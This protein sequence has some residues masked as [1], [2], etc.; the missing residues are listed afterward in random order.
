[1]SEVTELMGFGIIIMTSFMLPFIIKALHD[2]Y[3]KKEN[4]NKTALA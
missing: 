1:L 3:F 4:K 2:D